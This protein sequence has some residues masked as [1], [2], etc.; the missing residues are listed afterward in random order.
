MVHACKVS[1]VTALIWF[2]KI[3]IDTMAAAICPNLQIQ[4]TPIRF[5][6][7]TMIFNF[8]FGIRTHSFFILFSFLLLQVALFAA[9]ETLN[10]DISSNS[11]SLSLKMQI[12]NLIINS[13][14]SKIYKTFFG[15]NLPS[16]SEA[17]RWGQTVHRWGFS[18]T[19]HIIFSLNKCFTI[20]YLLFDIV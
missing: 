11:R 8:F 1:Y 12:V 5:L 20:Y 15:R 17:T 13:A 7:A 14:N 9:L 16:S 6:L 10:Q 18:N 4:G 3:Q 2:W 19:F